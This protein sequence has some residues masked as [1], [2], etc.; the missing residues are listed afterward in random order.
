MVIE[1]HICLGNCDKNFYL[2]THRWGRYYFRFGKGEF[3]VGEEYTK[4]TKH[5]VGLLSKKHRNFMRF[6]PFNRAT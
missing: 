6:S 5:D 3:R 4:R 1:G 2:V